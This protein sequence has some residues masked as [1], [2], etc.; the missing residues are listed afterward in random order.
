VFNV[1]D[2]GNVWHGSAGGGIWF[3]LPNRSVGGV[4][5]VVA[6]LGTG[7]LAELRVHVLD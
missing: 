6:G 2:D 3:S 1:T 4:V 5:T 7:P